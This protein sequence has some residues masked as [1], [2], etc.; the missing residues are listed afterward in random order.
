MDIQTYK[1]I[2]VILSLT[3]IALLVVIFFLFLDRR[4]ITLEIIE[5]NNKIKS[6]KESKLNLT[7]FYIGAKA[8]L[9]K[10]PMVHSPGNS[11]QKEFSV[12]FEVEVIDVSENQIK[13]NVI[14]FRGNDAFSRD[15][16]IKPAIIAYLN[17]RWVDKDL[18]EI[19]LDNSHNRNLKLEEL[20]IK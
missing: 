9:K 20:G 7:K 10:Y 4:K 17:N 15:I 2:I 8:I 6:E 3:P 12:D 11:I 1:N 14:D 16:K 13:V 19:V 5:L 18:A